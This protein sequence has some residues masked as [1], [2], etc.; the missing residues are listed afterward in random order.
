MDVTRGDAA[1]ATETR[2]QLERCAISD[3]PVV[4]VR[5][6]FWNSQSQGCEA[7]DMHNSAGCGGCGA[8]CPQTLN[9]SPLFGAPP[10]KVKGCVSTM[11][12]WETR[13][14]LDRRY[15][16]GAGDRAYGWEHPVHWRIM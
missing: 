10:R 7:V 3:P 14:K 16:Y 4:P 13:V 2:P 5:Q 8:N 11:M 1:S 6:K 9:A 12:R 15:G